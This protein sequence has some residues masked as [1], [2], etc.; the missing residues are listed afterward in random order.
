MRSH[1]NTNIHALT[2]NIS[3]NVLSYSLHG[4]NINDKGV[5]DACII[6]L[7]VKKEEERK[8]T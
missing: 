5:S 7:Q 2:C 8:A 1:T 4:N 3:I 6:L